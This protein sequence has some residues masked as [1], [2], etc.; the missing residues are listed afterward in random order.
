[1]H[2]TTW[3][4]GAAVVAAIAVPKA[5]KVYRSPDSDFIAPYQEVIRDTAAWRN[6]WAMSGGRPDARGKVRKL[7]NIN[8][9]R[10][11][12]V[13]AANPGTAGDSVVIQLDPKGARGVF[14]VITYKACTPS[15]PKTMPVDII[16]I[17]ADAGSVLFRDRTVKGP[18]CA[19]KPAT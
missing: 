15:A 10:K 16:A 6:V 4:L 14:N 12:V 1:M 13:V 18:A 3:C 7:T 17:P 2:T 11:M 19:T 8:F 9:K 5:Q